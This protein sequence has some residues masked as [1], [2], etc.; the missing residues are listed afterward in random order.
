MVEESFVQQVA[1]VQHLP[2]E[3]GEWGKGITNTVRETAA[4]MDA[5]DEEIRRMDAQKAELVRKKSDQKKLLKATVRRAETECTMLFADVQ[6]ETAKQKAVE[7][8]PQE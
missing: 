3:G 2:N 8:Q 7:P 6:I 4:M 5:F 1:W